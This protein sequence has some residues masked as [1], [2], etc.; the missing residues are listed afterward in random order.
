ME[1]IVQMK[2]TLLQESLLKLIS[3]RHLVFRNKELLKVKNITNEETIKI[4]FVVLV[5]PEPALNSVKILQ[6][7]LKIIFFSN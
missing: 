3:L 6:F 7:Y 4:P 2:K 5:L 1:N